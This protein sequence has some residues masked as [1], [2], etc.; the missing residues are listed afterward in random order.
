M[1]IDSSHSQTY[2]THRYL[3]FA[4]SFL[5]G[6]YA[7]YMFYYVAHL[8]YSG[9][10]LFFNHDGGIE[11]IAVDPGSPADQAGLKKGDRILRVGDGEIPWSLQPG[12]SYPVDYQRKNTLLHSQYSP[13]RPVFPV[14]TLT[15]FIF[16]L[17]F[18]GLGLTV[19]VRRPLD[20]AARV[21]Y[22]LMV[23]TFLGCIVIFNLKAVKNPVGGIAG[24]MCHFVPPLSLHFLLIF[25]EPKKILTRYR[26]LLPLSY[27]LPLVLFSY[28]GVL[29]VR[30]LELPQTGQYDLSLFYN[31]MWVTKTLFLLILV[32][33]SVGL[34]CLGHTFFT[35]T[36]F[37]VRKQ[38]QWILLGSTVSFMLVIPGLYALYQDLDLFMAGGRTLPM[39][40]VL[41][42]VL[43]F[44]S[45]CL[46]IFKYRLMDIE[47]VI[48]RSL[49]SFLISGV[50]ILFYFILFGILS[51]SLELLIGKSHVS[52]SIVSAAIV[53]FY[54]RPLLAR[55][56]EGIDKIFYR[57]KY[58]LHQALEVVSQALL[59]VRDPEEI[60]RK[61]F[62]TVADTLEIRSGILW[63]RHR[64]DD[65]LEPCV[66][67]PDGKKGSLPVLASSSPLP[68]YLA[69]TRVG[70]TRYQARTEGR[71]SEERN[72]YLEM[73][74]EASTEILLPLIYENVLMGII[75]LGGKRSGDLYSSED[76]R[77]LSTLANQAAVAM[78]NARAYHRIEQLNRNLEDKVHQIQHQ[79]QEILVLQERLL[80]ENTYLRE[81]MRQQFVF[82]EIIAS[83]PAMHN[84]IAMVE[85]IS[86]TASTVFLRGESGT[87]KELIARAIHFNSPRRE[88]SFVKVNCAAIPANLLESELFGHE[89]GAFTGA[90]KTKPG[91]L[92]LAD[93]GTLLL[94]EIGDMAMDIQAKVLRALQEREFERVG[95]TKTLS[96]DIRIIAA[97]N[98]DIEKA[99]T[100]N[101]FRED[102][103]YRL[104]VISITLPPLRDRKED[105]RELC[106]YFINKF[107]REMAKP[108]RNIDPEAMDCL[109]AY[110]WPGNVRE[111]A[112]ILER[113][114]GLGESDT[115]TV[116]DF[117]DKLTDAPTIA[118]SGEKGALP[119]A[120]ESMERTR[121]LE[122]LRKSG[123]N[124]SEAARL[125]GLKKSTLFSKLKKLK[126]P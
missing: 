74:E 58:A 79:Q 50:I 48:H 104:N 66:F 20:R 103:Y 106:I 75:G 111:L 27:L 68:Q 119:R 10:H 95:G 88:H 40:I 120:I 43:Y 114:V 33:F 1:K 126:I 3:L 124:K 115:I 4:L 82:E 36:N 99:I 87:G 98:R 35:T 65:I 85:K 92:E 71:F 21:F 44:I 81:E 8:P 53:A 116:D 24:L 76:L 108:V 11:V 34:L 59:K 84:V 57:E 6:A 29:I 2:R 63:L 67:L 39:V 23:C 56:Q 37:E 70:L 61:I 9:F 19:H 123:G 32:Y 90:M 77:L 107:S 86:P 96:A 25:P 69:K 60:F 55:I 73:F 49:S 105:I 72:H 91:K 17:L 89:K 83:S 97:T 41:A 26:F 93:G 30:T 110:R 102:L 31:V 16:G 5:A 62:K 28:H 42:M 101:S 117:P 38:L 12:R 54:V 122:A 94:D 45:Y 14:R 118:D 121:I 7:V 22:L 46:A 13:A 112:N 100:E 47:I 125:L 109:K 15:G 78:E 113:A 51:R 80:S 18:L 64:S 52:T